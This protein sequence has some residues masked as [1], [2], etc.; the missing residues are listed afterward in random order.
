[1]LNIMATKRKGAGQKRN[2]QFCDVSD[3]TEPT[4]SYT[5]NIQGVVT[6]VSQMLS[7][8]GKKLYYSGTLSDGCAKRCFAENNRNLLQ[9]FL[10]QPVSMTNCKSQKNPSRSDEIE[11]KI[12]DR[13]QM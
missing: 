11:F 13:S 3:T 2:L 7:S 1:M 8:P 9:Q 4:T 12:A 10:G 6:S 5:A